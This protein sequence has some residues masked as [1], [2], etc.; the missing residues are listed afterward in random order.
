MDQTDKKFIITLNETTAMQ[1]MHLGLVLLSSQ[2]G[3]WT[4]LNEPFK[5]NMADFESRPKE[6]VY[7]NMLNG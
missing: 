6:I 5:L 4:F 3:V 1:L 7:T 2:D